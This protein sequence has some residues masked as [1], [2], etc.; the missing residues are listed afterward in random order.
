LEGDREPNTKLKVTFFWPF[1]GKYWILDLA[2]DYSWARVGEPARKYLW[3]LSREPRMQET[4]YEDI[5]RRAAARGFDTSR[6][7]RAS[8]DPPAP[9]LS[10]PS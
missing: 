6:M 8:Q 5:L 1:S 9:A 4:V 10:D 3:V 7:S 2:P